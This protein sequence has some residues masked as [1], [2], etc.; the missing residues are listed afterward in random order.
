MMRRWCWEDCTRQGIF[1]AGD[2]LCLFFGFFF[3]FPKEIN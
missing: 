3:L 2:L 1:K